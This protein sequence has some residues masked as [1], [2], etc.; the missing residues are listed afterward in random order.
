MAFL[1]FQ[2]QGGG[3]YTSLYAT[4]ATWVGRK[5]GRNGGVEQDR[6]Y[7]G[8]VDKS[9]KTLRVGKGHVGGAGLTVDVKKLRAMLKDGEDVVA[10]FKRLAVDAAGFGAAPAA[11]P[12]AGS[13]VIDAFDKA[14]ALVGQAH[15]LKELAKD[16]GLDKALLDAFGAD[17]GLALLYLAMHQAVRGDPL[18]LAESWLDDLW[19]PDAL[20]E[21]DF[22]S[23]G[24]SRLMAWIGADIGSRQRFHKLWLE[25]RGKP[26]ALI[27]DTTSVST[28]ADGLETAGF[29]YNRD[30]E[31][32]PQ[33]NLAMVCA[34]EDGLPLFCRV[35][36]GSVPDV[37]TLENTCAM[38]RELGLEEFEYSL[39]RGFYSNANLRD[40][41]LCGIRFTVGAPLS[42]PQGRRL[43]REYKTALRSSKR[44]MP[45]QGR[46]Q[47]HACG[48][49][50]VDMGR[51]K[52][53]RK[54]AAK[55]IDAH[56]F[57][58]PRRHGD[59]VAEVE[60]RLFALEAKASK[61]DF[62]RW[63]QARAWIAENA[64]PLSSCLAPKNTD[65]GIRVRRLPHA[66]AVRNSNAGY[67]IVLCGE[68]GR[69]GGEALA[70]Y[71][72]RDKVEKVF[73][74]LKNE[75]E[76]YRLRTGNGSIAEGR[77]FLAFL[78]LVLRSTVESRLRKAGLLKNV[79][80]PEFLAEMGKIRAIRLA[81][82][83]RLIREITKRQRE[84][85]EKL[86]IT[87]PT[88]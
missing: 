66:V 10:W 45:F 59:R 84:W 28:Y 63:R 27:Y 58:D 3:K 5:K 1:T 25:A 49:W 82:G 15:V 32:L 31:S 37:R 86:G 72:S 73:D 70:D 65:D 81:S 79:S 53:G 54:R 77:V 67:T 29:G 23:S 9:C 19:L 24:L 4:S 40:M 43:L 17:K 21:F 78:G 69:E 52:A 57:F 26:K 7:L 36:P 8:R 38:L 75:N 85:L 64:G 61:E 22:S 6:T 56:V 68:R 76:Q 87:Q 48:T 16:I 34:K 83:A 60:E 46:C 20:A 41:L 55:L 74:I 42:Y 30:G 47:R 12:A 80:V 62:K 88:A 50:Q 71:R 33:I 14:T 18:Y 39:D 13:A 2:R 51:D 44:S 35:V 11:A